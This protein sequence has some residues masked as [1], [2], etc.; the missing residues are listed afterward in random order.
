MKKLI[1]FIVL[2]VTGCSTFGGDLI[3]RVS[4]SVPISESDRNIDK[5]CQLNMFSSEKNKHVGET[6][7]AAIFSTTMMVVAGPEP[8]KYYFVAD[9][10]NG[11]KFRSS[12]ISISSRRSYSN[13]FDLG[14]LFEISK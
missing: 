14:T 11:E 5:I 7:I 12:D 13:T 6:D 2:V 8:R 10:N 3:I 4:G 9:C 1:P